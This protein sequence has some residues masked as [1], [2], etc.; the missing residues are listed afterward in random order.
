[1]AISNTLAIRLQAI[2]Q[3]FERGMQ[4]ASGK[5]KQ[6][7]EQN[8]S[9]GDVIKNLGSTIANA[10]PVVVAFGAAIAGAGVAI[11]KTTDS[12]SR[13]AESLQK[14]S[15]RIGLSTQQLETLRF[16]AEQSGSNLDALVPTFRALARNADA[17]T[18]GLKLQS[19]AFERL[20]V[21]VL[22]AD[23]SFKELDVLLEE[24]ADGIAGLSN[25]TERLA[26]AQNVLGRGAIAL[27]PLLSGGSQAVRDLREEAESLGVSIS[28]QFANESAEYVDNLNRIRTAFRALTNLVA[29][30]F[31]PIFNEVL[32]VVVD[33]AK[34][35]LPVLSDAV[36]DAAFQ[37]RRLNAVTVGVRS[38]FQGRS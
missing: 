11:V 8:K 14:M 17:A 32:D 28:T 4:R 26:V 18:Q 13:Y 33:F 34:N 36:I 29:Q 5:V 25:S 9:L 22:N 15:L 3:G 2:T 35:A 7:S 27:L 10:N 19:D 21:D 37:L 31:L 38:A 12:A 24:V 23:G 6:F 16:A 20:G 1:M 30:E